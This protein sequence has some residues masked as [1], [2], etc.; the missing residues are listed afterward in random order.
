MISVLPGLDQQE[1]IL[2]FVTRFRP[3]PV[4]SPPSAVLPVRSD[5][6]LCYRENKYQVT[7][8]NR[9]KDGHEETMNLL[10][11]LCFRDD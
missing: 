8:A 4:I 10:I 11:R 7:R 9:H 3:Y 2:P 6:L 1:V 5:A